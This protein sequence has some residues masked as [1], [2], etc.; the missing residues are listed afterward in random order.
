MNLKRA[1][2]FFAAVCCA[3]LVAAA[4]EAA[5]RVVQRIPLGG[6]GGWDD[7]AF[8]SASHRI[9]FSRS[10]RVLVVDAEKGKLLGEIPGTA[11][12]HGI[13]LAPE[14]GRGYTSNGR[15]NTVSVFDLATLKVT[16]E[17]KVTG[18]NPDAILYD[19]FTQRIF[20]FNGRT[21]NATV[22]D[23]KDGSVVATIPL[24]G[25]PEFAASDGKG[26]IFVNIE[27]KQKLTVI[28]PRTAKV[29]A[30]WSL[31]PGEDP[32]GL[33][34]DVGHQ[35]LFAVCGNRK[36]IVLDAVSGRRIA[37]LPIGQGADA[38]AFDPGQELIFS[39]NGEGTLTIVHEDDPDHFRVVATVPTQKGARTLA[40]DPAGHRV[41][42]PAA[43]YG[44]AP[45]PTPEQPR[46]RPAML[47]DSFTLLV[48]GQR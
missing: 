2:L 17:I 27:D 18:Q 8:D 37:D 16:A 44:P 14:L 4:P 38:V 5:Y 45:A 12:V 47:P 46:P 24:D 32:T 7:L 34:M 29:V 42:L 10:D 26:R 33:A 20:T 21:A 25:K 43:E 11:G 15:A 28:D 13:A 40:L 1:G 31:A 3:G 23:A 30:N 35:R 39:S 48:V 19:S 22:I 36:L 41:F 9:F 6:A